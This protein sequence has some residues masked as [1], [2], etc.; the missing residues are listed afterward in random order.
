[1]KIQKVSIFVALVVSVSVSATPIT[2][3]CIQENQNEKTREKVVIDLD[4]D[5][6]R[7]K[8]PASKNWTVYSGIDANTTK[9]S[10]RVN[11]HLT[12]TLDR[13]TLVLRY[14]MKGGG[15]GPLVSDLAWSLQ[16]VT[17]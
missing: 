9:V 13:L 14:Q 3:D 7:V 6:F 16:C 10:A 8:K 17:E 4:K 11:K 5:E 12:V 2:L 1:M 15:D